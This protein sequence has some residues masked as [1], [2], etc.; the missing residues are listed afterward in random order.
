MTTMLHITK[1][2]G[3]NEAADAKAS[4]TLPF[5]LR[6]KSR[7]RA[8]LDSGEEVGLFLPRGTVLR[9]GDLLEA[10]NGLMI[11]VKAAHEELS[12]VSTRDPMLLARVCYHLGNRHAPV[13]IGENRVS[14]LHDHVL[15]EM[16]RGLGVEVSVESGPFTPE[17][18]AY[19]SHQGHETR[20]E[21]SEHE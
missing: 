21:I 17:S 11:R 19:H 18:G 4:L 12:T 2:L 1:C 9:D 14:Y 5:A 7:Q 3:R 15:D 13:E 20:M 6:E 10:E 8:V 16:V